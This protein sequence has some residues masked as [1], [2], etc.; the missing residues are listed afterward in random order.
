M[1]QAWRFRV[2]NSRE[3][4]VSGLLEMT[5]TWYDEIMRIA[6]SVLSQQ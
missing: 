3:Y 5:E 1:K 6:L 2:L 4:I